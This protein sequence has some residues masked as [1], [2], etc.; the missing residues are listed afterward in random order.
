MVTSPPSNHSTAAEYKLGD[1]YNFEVEPSQYVSS[2][3]FGLFLNLDPECL[4]N[5]I[6][7][8]IS[9]ISQAFRIIN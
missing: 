6:K 7:I 4:V 9:E 3:T 5:V 1:V 8:Q 2:I